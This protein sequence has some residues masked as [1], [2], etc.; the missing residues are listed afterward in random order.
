MTNNNLPDPRNEI[1]RAAAI[2]IAAIPH[3]SNEEK[4]KE[5]KQEVRSIWGWCDY[6]DWEAAGILF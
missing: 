6:E 1:E 2:R 4:V 5:F 3:L